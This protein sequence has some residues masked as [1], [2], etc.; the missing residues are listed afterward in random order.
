MIRSIIRT[1]VAGALV[2]GALLAGGSAASAQPLF[3]PLQPIAQLDVQRYAGDWWQ[4]AAV[5]QPFNLNC[6]KAPGPT[7]RCSTPATCA[8]RTTAPAGTAEPTRSSATPG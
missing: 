4:I 8:C 6:A 1:A 2:T 5:P 7:T 3:E